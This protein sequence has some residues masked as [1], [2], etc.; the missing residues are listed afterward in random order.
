MAEFEVTGV[1][2]QMGDH[3]D[4]DELTLRA[5]KYIHQLQNGTPMLLVAEPDN[6]VDADAVAVYTTEFRKVGYIKHE[7]CRQLKPMLATAPYLKADVCGNDNHVTFFINVPDVTECHLSTLQIQRQL[8]ESIL[9]TGITLPFTEEERKLQLIAPMLCSM[10]ISAEN[11]EQWLS[12]AQHYM[13][14]S[15]L[16]LTCEDDYWRD[17]IFKKFRAVKQLNLSED[18]QKKLGEMN[19]ELRQTIGDFHYTHVPWQPKVFEAQLAILEKQA[20]AKGGFFE[21]FNNYVKQESVARADIEKKL[22]DWFKAMPHVDM[23]N[24]NNHQRLAIALSYLGISRQ[25]LYDV[26]AALLLLTHLKTAHKA[27]PAANADVVIEKLSPVFWGITEDAKEFYRQIQGMKPV[28]ITNLVKKLIKQKNISQSRAH[29][30][31]WQVLHDA[32]LYPPSE[33]NWNDQLK[34]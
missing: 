26:F 13:P 14:L 19:K 34:K 25:E 20:M 18:Q 29:R 11:V 4:I 17:Q 28:E 10:E 2:Y 6:I 5:E 27:S 8:P 15:R 22:K 16:S 33:S 23:Q 30:D 3:M 7:S 24:Y 21:H 1:R 9:P 32:G 12:M 31:L